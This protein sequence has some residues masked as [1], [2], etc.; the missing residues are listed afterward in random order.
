MSKQNIDKSTEH[1]AGENALSE[2]NHTIESNKNN[3]DSEED[4]EEDEDYDPEKK[5]EAENE[6]GVSSDEEEDNDQ[7]KDGKTSKI[8]DYST[9]ESSTS[10]VKTRS[11]R[12]HEKLSNQSRFIGNFEVDSK[13]GLVKDQS[14]IDV[15]SIFENLKN[16]SPSI[17]N[18]EELNIDSEKTANSQQQRKQQSNIEENELQGPKQ[19]K[20]QI[21][22]TFAGKL[23][24]E[25]KYVDENSQEAKAY[26]NSTSNISSSNSNEDIP[27]RRSQVKV[28]RTDP[29]TNETK[30][31]RIKLKRPS[32]IDRFLSI[33]GNSKKMKLSTLEK[34]RLD[35]ASFVD[36]RNINEE[37]KI[38]NKAGYL[39]KQDFINRMNSKRDDLYLQAK[40]KEKIRKQQ[41]LQK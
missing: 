15:N 34:S 9:I 26:L 29:V 37:L 19:I 32:L 33:N 7:Y 11:Q 22:Y 5:N 35:W 1:S 6:G 40:E 24:T 41:L 3:I 8:P 31:L 38:H 12:L 16:G 2:K 18:S 27:Y 28:I 13:T 39:D 17:D 25:T 23:I 20:I 21:N 14:N 10:Q 36:K 4:D 30:E